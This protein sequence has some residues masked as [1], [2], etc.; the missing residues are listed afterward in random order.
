[1]SSYCRD[2]PLSMALQAGEL[3][4]GWGS[5]GCNNEMMRGESSQTG[6]PSGPRGCP[7]GGPRR[8]P[9]LH[10][11]QPP[12]HHVD[13]A[14]PAAHLTHPSHSSRFIGAWALE[15]D[16]SGFESY[17]PLTS[18]AMLGVTDS[19]PRGSQFLACSMRL[20][21]CQPS[22]YGICGSCWHC[23]HPPDESP[24]LHHPT[25]TGWVSSP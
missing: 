6:L 19:F 12:R 25:N 22:V 18:C 1:M 3:D 17:P 5:I 23:C 14:R 13:M 21:S 15:S 9:V 11:L 8:C 24:S 2:P 20:T 4:P 10:T 7:P 16:S